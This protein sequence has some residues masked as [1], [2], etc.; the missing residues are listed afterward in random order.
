MVSPASPRLRLTPS[1]LLRICRSSCFSANWAGELFDER[2][3]CDPS[4]ETLRQRTDHYLSW[5]NGYTNNHDIIAPM[6][7]AGGVRFRMKE[8]AFVSVAD[9]AALPAAADRIAPRRIQD[10]LDY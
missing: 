9:P 6:L 4:K 5:V 1:I 7:S 3:T 10:R 2:R 8:N